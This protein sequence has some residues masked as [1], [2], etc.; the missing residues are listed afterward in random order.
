MT[1]LS[2]SVPSQSKNTASIRDMPFLFNQFNVFVEPIC[3]T[4]SLP[5][6]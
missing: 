3:A 6:K 1:S 4:Q 2:T 5:Y